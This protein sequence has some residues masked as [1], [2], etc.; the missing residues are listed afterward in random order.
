MRLKAGS[1]CK[2]KNKEQGRGKISVKKNLICWG[3]IVKLAWD[4]ETHIEPTVGLGFG[5]WLTGY[6]VFM[7]TQNIYRDMK[8]VYILVCRH[9][10]PG[11]SGSIFQLE[12]SFSLYYSQ[13]STTQQLRQ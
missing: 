8:C 1:F 12:I 6:T 4:K 9:G 13:N 10:T 3:H 11:R 7:V 5:D 2:V